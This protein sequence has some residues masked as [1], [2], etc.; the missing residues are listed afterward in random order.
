M[1]RRCCW[2]ETDGRALSAALP[3]PGVR[4]AALPWTAF[5][6]VACTFVG[7]DSDAL[8]PVFLAFS[9]FALGARPL[10]VAEPVLRDTVT[11][12]YDV[13]R[14]SVC[15]VLTFISFAL[16]TSSSVLDLLWVL[17]SALPVAS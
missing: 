6:L 11:Q 8:V 17:T 7:A 1:V 14:Q 9:I 15:L 5:A 3:W 4:D 13:L 2:V 10:L 12:P 16:L